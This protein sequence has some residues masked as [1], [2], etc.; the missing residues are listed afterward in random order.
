[1][2]GKD[3][4]KGLLAGMMV[5]LLAGNLTAQG[6][7]LYETGQSEEAFETEETIRPCTDEFPGEYVEQETE[8]AA[9]DPETEAGEDG[10]AS[11]RVSGIRYAK[12]EKDLYDTLLKVD[13]PIYLDYELAEE[14]VMDAAAPAFGDAGNS[15]AKTE[16]MTYDSAPEAEYS[17]TNVRTEGVDEADIIKTDGRYIYI[18]RGGTELITVEAKGSETALV[19]SLKI[20]QDSTWD[21]PGAQELLLSEGKAY[22]ILEE[23]DLSG[24]KI[25]KYGYYS[26]TNRM[27]KL[28][29]VDM[30][31]PFEPVIEDEF[32]LSGNYLQSRKMD[33]VI[34]LFT[35]WSPYLG[36]SAED[37][38]LLPWIGGRKAEVSSV[39][40]PSIV[41]QTSYLT[42]ASVRTDAP[43]QAEDYCT[44]VSG[45]D[46][47]Y[48]STDSIYAVNVD[49][50]SS[51]TSSEITKLTFRDGEI[52]GKA[53]GTVRGTVNNSFSLDEYNGYLRVLT[54]YWGSARLNLLKVLGQLFGIDYYDED[55]WVRHNALFVLDED[56]NYAGS[57]KDLARN[58]EIK[59]ARFFGDTVYFV[60]F[61]NT[62]PLFTADLSDPSH[63]RVIGEL[64]LP[65]FSAYLH[66]FGEGKLLGLGYD[67]DELTGVTSG[68]KLSLFDIS[69]PAN[70][71]ETA[72]RIVPGVTWCPAVDE[73]KAIFAN[74]ARNLVGFWCEGRYMVFAWDGTDGFERVLL[75]DFFEDDLQE[76]NDYN[77]MRGLYIGDV[78][79][80][81]GAGSV[82]AFDMDADFQKTAVVVF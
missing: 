25:E 27:T 14:S 53:A 33:G 21:S 6:E 67:A 45:A 59:S 70:V 37:S 65:G 36:G 51:V 44:V 29:T 52:E 12:S 80:L 42:A 81:A 58:E 18:L 3:C 4:R 16:A 15:A 8:A 7:N 66:P 40:I 17:E 41:T 74:P 1:M 77:T 71:K 60:T 20:A 64:K 28:I 35:Q 9:E 26:P 5:V 23:S 2:S 55:E 10:S 76:K 72:R 69:D 62:D 73:Y 56:M 39:I 75:Y 30:T 34:Y 13:V 47:F 54:T 22:V 31:D 57:L 32:S 61:R 63:P 48:V 79:Y 82:I 68:L 78:F 24:D 11:V 38:E 46:E 43:G 19:S 50:W 49:N